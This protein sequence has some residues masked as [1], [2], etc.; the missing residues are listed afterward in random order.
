MKIDLTNR[1]SLSEMLRRDGTS[2]IIPR[3][4]EA[5]HIQISGDN[6]AGKSTL[7]RKMLY[8]IE[9]RGETAIVFDP[10]REFIPEFYRPEREHMIWNPM[11][12]RC[13]RWL[14]EDE[15]YSEAVY[16]ATAVGLFPTKP[17][18]QV[19]F[20]EHSVAILAYVLNKFHPDVE[21]LCEWL[22]NEK[23]MDSLLVGST[24]AVTL[25][26]NSPPQRSGILGTLNKVAKALRMLPRKTEGRDTFS[27]R[28]WIEGGRRGWIFLSCTP[29]TKDALLP[30]ITLW[31]DSLILG[32]QVGIRRPDQNRVWTVMDEVASLNVLPKLLDALTQN[33][34]S[35]NPII[36]GLQNFSMVRKLYGHD[37]A[38]A[39]L[40]QA[41]TNFI[42]RSREPSTAEHMS[43]LI[44]YR[45]V[46]RITETRRSSIFGRDG[47][48]YAT[49]IV[50]EPVVMASEIQGLPN[51][52]GYCSHGNNV[53]KI[54]FKPNPRRVLADGLI[55]RTVPAEPAVITPDAQKEPEQAALRGNG[56]RITRTAKKQWRGQA[57]TEFAMDGRDGAAGE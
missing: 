2:L 54:N 52:S 40:S 5:Q 38:E 20:N 45:E 29:D 4:L 31:L 36:M 33:R 35:D 21:T 23:K 24:H 42:L 28:K 27:V 55:E 41:Y 7:I 50:T 18:E 37:Q 30:L 9:R 57:Q 14:I 11:D 25:N 32:L 48:S 46:E 22:A 56:Q 6:G 39:M 12:N 34:A 13:F 10:K 8:E 16:T 3:A 26:E 47:R 1:R 17:T 49:Q 44:G 15:A 19:W 51:L 43:K 53:V